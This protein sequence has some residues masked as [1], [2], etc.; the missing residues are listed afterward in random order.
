MGADAYVYNT[1]TAS[2]LAMKIP[3]KIDFDALILKTLEGNENRTS[4]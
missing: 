1:G 2:D 4:V 3:S